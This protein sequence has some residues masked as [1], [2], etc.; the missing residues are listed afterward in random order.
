VL[1]FTAAASAS[2]RLAMET[3]CAGRVDGGGAVLRFDGW[4]GAVLKGLCAGSGGAIGCQTVEGG[5][6]SIR[7]PEIQA[8]AA[9]VLLV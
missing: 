3:G 5:F 7:A 1:E 9:S 2:A 4:G 6:A 8:A